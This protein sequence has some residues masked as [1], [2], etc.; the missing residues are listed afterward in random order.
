MSKPRNSDTTWEK[1]YQKQKM[2]KNLHVSSRKS[3]GTTITISDYLY[4]SE[5]LRSDLDI[6]LQMEKIK[7]LINSFVLL[8]SGISFSVRDDSAS[9]HSYDIYQVKRCRNTM[10]AAEQLFRL[11][12]NG[13]LFPFHKTSQHFRIKGLVGNQHLK[14]YWFVYVNNRPI[15]SVEM[16]S[17]IA[18]IFQSKETVQNRGLVLNIKV[19]V[20]ITW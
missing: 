5:R 9:V 8:H 10:E 18:S 14:N 19:F 16:N 7:S 12:V 1:S 11:K 3:C 17:L 20:N 13:K 15:E 4:A 6:P 2:I